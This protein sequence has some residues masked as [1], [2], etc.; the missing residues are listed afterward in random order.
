VDGDSGVKNPKATTLDQAGQVRELAFGR[1]AGEQVV[2][3]AVYS[4]N[5]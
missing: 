2:G 3:R 5:E 4:D 1:P